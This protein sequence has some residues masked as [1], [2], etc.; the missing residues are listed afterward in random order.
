MQ[1]PLT[2]AWPSRGSTAA[3]RNT[4]SGAADRKPFSN[5]RFAPEYVRRNHDLFADQGIKVRGAYLDVFSVVPM[6]ESA[7][8]AHPVTRA[9]C[10]G[11]RRECF[12]LLQ[13]R[14]YVVSSE[15]PTDYLVGSLDLVHHGPYSTSPNIGGGDAT[16][17]PVPLFNLV[18]HDCL[19]VPWDM[20]D[21][22][23]WGIPNGDAGRLHCLLNAGL[24]YVGPGADAQQIARVNEAAGAGRPL[25]RTGDDQPRIPRRPTQAAHDLQRWDHRH[26][27]LR[28]E[29]P[30][31][32]PGP[33]AVTAA[34]RECRSLPA[35]STGPEHDVQAALRS[36]PVALTVRP[37]RSTPRKKRATTLLRSGPSSP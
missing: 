11:F 18:Y 13:A 14:G 10:A 25:R 32:C 1:F 30:R 17:I 22:G 28:R 35:C 19:L 2:T 16:G 36:G 15:E 8:A 31:D 20:G 21:D 9:E 34:C 33:T 27:G 4:A 7:Q 24:P 29:D 5:P 37:F 12:D 6:E 26:R 23:G 3:G